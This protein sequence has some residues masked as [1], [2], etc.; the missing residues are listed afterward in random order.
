MIW[1]HVTISPWP[2]YYIFY[3]YF[4]IVE[5]APYRECKAFVFKIFLDVSLIGWGE[6]VMNF[7]GA[8][9]MKFIALSA[10]H[11]NLAYQHHKII[12]NLIQ[13]ESLEIPNSVW[14]H[15]SHKSS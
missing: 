6:G 12:E 13:N 11:F 7:P 15:G 2:C 14:N 4:S 5:I 3:F 8:R 10:V 1:R 9:V